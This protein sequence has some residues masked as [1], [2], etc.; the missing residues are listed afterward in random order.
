V[1]SCVGD[2]MFVVD[3]DV[4]IIFTENETDSFKRERV[5]RKRRQRQLKTAKLHRTSKQRSEDVSS[6]RYYSTATCSSLATTGTVTPLSSVDCISAK[7]VCDATSIDTGAEQSQSS[8]DMASCPSD[9]VSDRLTDDNSDCCDDGSEPGAHHT[10][11][12]FHKY[13]IA[14]S[15]VTLHVASFH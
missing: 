9:T 8:S 13:I 2:Y 4:D 15:S 1:C 5:L 7:C 3:G 11:D 6:S 14:G 10:K 12:A